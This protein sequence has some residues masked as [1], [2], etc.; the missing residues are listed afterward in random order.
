VQVRPGWELTLD[1]TP[2][3]VTADV[4]LESLKA[5]DRNCAFTS[6][7]FDNETFVKYTQ[8]NCR[9]HYKVTNLYTEFGCIPWDVP[10]KSSKDGK[11]L[12]VCSLE[13]EKLFKKQLTDKFFRKDEKR[14]CPEDC[15]VISYAQNTHLE[16]I[17]PYLE[18]EQMN[19]SFVNPSSNFMYPHP[20]LT[21]FNRVDGLR[22]K[23]FSSHISCIAYLKGVSII[24]MRPGTSRVTVIHQHRRVTFATQLAGLGKCIL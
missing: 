8:Q 20:M 23:D 12:V 16:T 1:L 22:S 11:E 6:E 13:E 9:Y 7:V 5:K 4:N 14:N 19:E 18:C 15:E 3:L 24:R 21:F 10:Y 17:D 2:S